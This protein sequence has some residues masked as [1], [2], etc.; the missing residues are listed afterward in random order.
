MFLKYFYNLPT[1][2]SNSEPATKWYVDGKTI[3][4]EKG[5]Y[6]GNGDKTKTITFSKNIF[7]FVVVGYDKVCEAIKDNSSLYNNSSSIALIEW[8]NNEITISTE[9]QGYAD[10]FNRKGYFYIYFG[11]FE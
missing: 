9:I 6:S 3:F 10:Y 1:P 4:Y 2:T 7:Y 5:D 8:N 11:L